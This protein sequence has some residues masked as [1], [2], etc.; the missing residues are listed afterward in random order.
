M[1]TAKDLANATFVG[2]DVATRQ[3]PEWLYDDQLNVHGGSKDQTVCMPLF[4]KT[5]PKSIVGRDIVM[6]V[7]YSMR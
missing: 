2:D 4:R 1:F 7:G 5:L 6:I 3:V